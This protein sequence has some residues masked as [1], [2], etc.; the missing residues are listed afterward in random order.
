M[1][2][3]PGSGALAAPPAGGSALPGRGE[4][5]P[6]GRP[7]SPGSRPYAAAAV[8]PGPGGRTCVCPPPLFGDGGR[9]LREELPA[10]EGD[11][12][13]DPGSAPRERFRMPGVFHFQSPGKW[14]CVD[15]VYPAGTINQDNHNVNPRLKFRFE[16]VVVP[17]ELT[18]RGGRGETNTNNRCPADRGGLQKPPSTRAQAV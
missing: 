18:E 12:M 16:S 8:A 1:R 4:A 15:R 17:T 14:I 13:P 2:G 5:G 7:P 10:T 11:S 9:R 3:P 6:S